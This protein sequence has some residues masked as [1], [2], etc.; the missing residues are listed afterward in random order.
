M[1]NAISH[2]TA[3]GSTVNICSL[4]LSKAFDKMNHYALL[5]KLMNR[6]FPI[7]LLNVLEYWLRSS[8]TCAR[9]RGCDSSFFCLKAG[10]RQGGILSP[11]LFAI[12]IDDVIAKVVAANVGC[13]ISLVNVCVFLYA[14][15]ILLLSPTLSGLQNLLAIVENELRIIDM[16]IN[17]T[18]S[19]CIRIGD[20][21]N[22]KCSCIKT[23]NGDELKWVEN[24]KYLGVYLLASRSFKCAFEPAK[25]KFF[26]S[27]NA[28]FGKIGRAAS[29]EV[30]I[31]LLKAKCLPVLLYALEAC[32]VSN[33]DRRSLDFSVSRVL[34]KVFK[35]VSMTVIRE[36]QFNFTFLPIFSLLDI[37][38]AKFL[39]NFKLSDNPLCS[40]FFNVATLRIEE[41]FR[42]HNNVAS[43]GQ[44]ITVI[45]STRN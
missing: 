2:F 29:E 26:R 13:H 12:F 23:F 31:A 43:I 40:I 21:F 5:I 4:D 35:T 37:R 25:Q 33:R 41:L 38:E 30:V 27:F 34:M 1:R 14:D 6:S 32:P 39:A 16:R 17:A 9:W 18:K 3:N 42:T 8:I 15:D 20:R 36:V 19:V 11:F 28:I 10:V 7:K 24:C 44:M 22:V 45:S